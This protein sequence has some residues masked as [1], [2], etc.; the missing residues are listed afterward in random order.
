MAAAAAAPDMAEHPAFRDSHE[1]PFVPVP[2]PPRRTAPNSR[3]GLTDSAVPGQE[4]FI[5]G[6]GHRLGGG[7]GSGGSLPTQGPNRGHHAGE[8][9]AAGAAG[10]ALGAAAVH[11]HNKDRDSDSASQKRYSANRRSLTRKPVPDPILTGDGSDTTLLNQ[12]SNSPTLSPFNSAGRHRSHSE[13]ALP[14]GGAAAGTGALGGAAVADHHKHHGHDTDSG[15]FSNRDSNAAAPRAATPLVPPIM[16]QSHHQPTAMPPDYEMLPNSENA[17]RNSRPISGIAPAAALGAHYGN[18]ES[19]PKIKRSARNSTPPAVPSRSPRRTRFSD[20]PYDPTNQAPTPPFGAIS[21]IDRD[22]NNSSN[23]SSDSAFRL[24]SSIPGGWRRDSAESDHRLRNSGINQHGRRSNS[25]T[26]DARDFA[27]RDSG[28]SGMGTMPA[29]MT[30]ARRHSP[31]L[32]PGMGPSG[33]RH[34]QSPGDITS[35]RVRLSDLRAEEE[36]LERERQRGRR[37][38]G[39]Q[40][41]WA[42][43]NGYDGY[44]KGSY[45]VGQAL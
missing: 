16:T 3:V 11:H 19:S 45:G 2:P 27:S 39:M 21:S 40:S 15:I 1:N 28:V 10:A 25:W 42:G 5:S 29:T 36:H 38:G 35:E 8:A 30:G 44:E 4:P 26:T 37:Y 33:R 34:S 23:S 41:E 17:Y 20:V 32:N 9:L 13:E 31:V 12:P 6:N 24:S 18:R 43:G 14:A 22:G 7:N